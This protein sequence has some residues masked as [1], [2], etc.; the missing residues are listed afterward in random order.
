MAVMAEQC[1]DL[2]VTVV[3]VDE[4]KIQAWN[5]GPL[6]VKEPHLEEI[7]TKARGRNLHF[8][9]DVDKAV[10]DADMVF[11]SVG[12]PT[13]STGIGAGRAALLDYVEGAAR[14]IARCATRPIIIVE[15]STVPVGVC[16][17]I[18]TLVR[19]NR[20]DLVFQVLS[21]PEFLAE[22][23]AVKDLR[24]PDRVLIGHQDSPEGAE[25]SE[26]LVSI[27]A[28]WVDREKI[29]LTNTWSSEL[30]KLSANAMLAQRVSSINSISAIC[31]ETGADVNEVARAIGSD[32]RLG[33]RFLKASVGFGGSCFQKDVLSL[34]YI[35]E[36]QHLKEVA[37]YWQAVV[38]MN[39]FLRT[40]FARLIV[41]KM[42]STLGKKKIGILGFAFKADTGDTRES[43]AI[44]IC[45]LM[46]AEGALVRIYDP[47]VSEDQIFFDLNNIDPSLTREKFDRSVTVFSDPYEALNEVHAI[48]VMTEWKEF[49]TYDYARI[50]QSMAKP[51]FC[52]DGRNILDLKR[53]REIGFKTHAIGVKPDDKS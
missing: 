15:K 13:K 38:D 17:K 44:Y 5:E 22:G 42:F 40:R 4:R 21:N 29:L 34:V 11:I 39:C 14:T 1:P 27:Y 7:V 53:L 2:T 30:S 47:E 37:A 3:D 23:T 52:F 35:A 19:I 36:S 26:A 43:A 48:I 41:D 45:S 49:R 24:D 46:L 25:A 32:V 12:T 20:K 16:E 51:A 18:R 9:T 31:E 6:P 8:T 33:N 28:R 10:G 50:Y